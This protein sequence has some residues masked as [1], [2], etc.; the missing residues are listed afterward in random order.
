M[1][2]ASV[3]IEMC[4]GLERVKALLPRLETCPSASVCI[5]QLESFK[6]LTGARSTSGQSVDNF[7]KEGLKCTI[8]KVFEYCTKWTTLLALLI[9]LLGIC[10]GA[11]LHCELY[12]VQGFTRVWLYW[13]N[14]DLYSEQ[15]R[16]INNKRLLTL[17]K[18]KC[19]YNSKKWF[20]VFFV[21]SCWLIVSF[22]IP[23][24][25]QWPL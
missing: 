15:V 6:R 7:Q 13:E 22:S 20:L 9:A 14:I 25:R 21:T 19:L 24:R 23:L 16:T 8:K 18:R 3:P 17:H 10:V 1:A 2:S 5:V 11:V 12:T 4:E